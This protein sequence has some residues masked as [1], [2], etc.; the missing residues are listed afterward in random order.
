M[1]REA[2]AS[3]NE[4]EFILQA[5]QQD[6]RLDGRALDSVRELLVSFGEEHGVAD[7]QLGKTRYVTI[8]PVLYERPD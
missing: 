8:F 6:I 2:E 4:Q 7:I 1:P 5:L 3:I